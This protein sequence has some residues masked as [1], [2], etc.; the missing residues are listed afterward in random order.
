MIFSVLI[1]FFFIIATLLANYRLRIFSFKPTILGAI[2][3]LAI[4]I[5][6]VPG[7]ILVSLYNY[8]M[9]FGVEQSITAEAKIATLNYTFI[10]ISI[11]LFTTVLFSYVYCLDVNFEK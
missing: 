9:S 4:F 6:I 10:S 2:F 7:T 5:Q 3:L 8:P 1:M 11:L